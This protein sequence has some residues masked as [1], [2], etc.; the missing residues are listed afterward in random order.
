M[1]EASTPTAT[2]TSSTEFKWKA[3]T[4]RDGASQTLRGDARKPQGIYQVLPDAKHRSGETRVRSNTPPEDIVFWWDGKSVD[5]DKDIVFTGRGTPD[6]RTCFLDIESASLV[7]ADTWHDDYL[8]RHESDQSSF[9]LHLAHCAQPVGRFSSTTCTEC[10]RILAS[11]EYRLEQEAAAAAAPT[12]EPRPDAGAV[13][14]Q[15]SDEIRLRNVVA[16]LRR[17]LDAARQRAERM[18]QRFNDVAEAIRD[19]AEARDWCDEYERFADEWNLPKR[20]RVYDVTVGV[21]VPAVIRV[22]TTSE[23]A[24]E[25]AVRDMEKSDLADEIRDQ[26]DSGTLDIISL[27]AE[28]AE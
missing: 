5:Y 6:S 19:E 25:Q 1:T 16:A 8:R 4:L 23:E 18:E 12:P 27:S 28:Q 26:L 20:E 24:A 14:A 2:P 17:E 21:S 3:S 11:D 22:S 9:C 13:Q 10:R 15:D 7:H